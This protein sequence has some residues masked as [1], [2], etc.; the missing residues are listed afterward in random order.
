AYTCYDPKKPTFTVTV[1]KEKSAQGDLYRGKE[2]KG[3]MY[4]IDIKSADARVLFLYFEK[5]CKSTDLYI[6]SHPDS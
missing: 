4:A 3:S 6:Q 5:K 2:R 1:Y